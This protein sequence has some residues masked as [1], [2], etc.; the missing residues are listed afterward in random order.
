MLKNFN[1][2]MNND[3]QSIINQTTDLLCR[4]YSSWWKLKGSRDEKKRN[5]TQEPACAFQLDYCYI[6]L[7]NFFSVKNKFSKDGSFVVTHDKKKD[8]IQ[9]KMKVWS[10]IFQTLFFSSHQHDIISRQDVLLSLLLNKT[11]KN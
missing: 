9:H 4:R 10:F 11:E 6:W 8:L 7:R 3:Y 2:C 5:I 1:C